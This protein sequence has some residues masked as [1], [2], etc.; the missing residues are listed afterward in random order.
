MMIKT[1]FLSSDL[2]LLNSINNNNAP[3]VGELKSISLYPVKSGGELAVDAWKIGMG[4]LEMDRQFMVVGSDGVPLTQ[5]KYPSMC[6]IGCKV[7]YF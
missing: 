1:C 4:G 6:F 3:K 2:S 7:S 5:R